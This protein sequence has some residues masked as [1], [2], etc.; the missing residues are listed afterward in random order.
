MGSIKYKHL[1]KTIIYFLVDPRTN[2]IR[3][4]GKTNQKLEARIT[5]HMRDKENSYKVHW[6]NQLKAEG[7]RP[8]GEILCYVNDD[9][10]WKEKE[11]YWIAEMKR[12]GARLTNNTIGGDGVSGVTGE[13]KK[14]M[15]ATW[16]GRKHSPETIEKL[17]AARAKRVTSEET[18][19]KMSQS[20]KGRKIT[21]VDAIAE[22]N[23][24]LSKEK[25]AW[26][27][28][29]IKSGEKVI[30]IARELGIHRTTISK[31]KSG[32]YFK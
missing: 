21:W 6:L 16:K 12:M 10:C 11:I 17:K 22:A 9:E 7:L 18:R 26:I 19:R 31:I 2:E 8:R 1:P 25:A 30:T 28:K 13:S 24:K 20:Q 27:K 3:Y 4:V 23:R 15:L 5:S 14:R 32:T 29:R